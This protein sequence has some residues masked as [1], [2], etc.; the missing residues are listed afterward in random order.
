METVGAPPNPL[1]SRALLNSA[2]RGDAEAGAEFL[3]RYLPDL[4]A[5]A[6][7]YGTL[8][9]RDTSTAERE[10][11]AEVERSLSAIARRVRRFDSPRAIDPWVW[12]IALNVAFSADQTGGGS[13]PP[14]YAAAF[15]LRS[16]FQLDNE[17]IAAVLG[18]E[19]ERI[20]SRLAHARRLLREVWGE[21][22]SVGP[23]AEYAATIDA[24]MDDILLGNDRARVAKHIA[25]CAGCRAEVEALNRVEESFATAMRGAPLARVDLERLGTLARKLWDDPPPQRHRSGRRRESLRAPRRLGLWSAGLAVVLLIAL[26]AARC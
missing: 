4:H 2:R 12:R 25:E 3:R 6:L 21:S 16:L 23:C 11:L 17:A 14:A 22:S 26:W 8:R 9:G 19:P 5:I 18:V 1:P 15:L 24:L 13:L 20:G 10:A 7:A